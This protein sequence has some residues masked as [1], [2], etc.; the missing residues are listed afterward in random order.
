MK[1]LRVN[2]E[3]TSSLGISDAQWSARPMMIGVTSGN[4]I[5]VFDLLV[6]DSPTTTIENDC[7]VTKLAF[8]KSGSV[9]GTISTPFFLQRTI[10]ITHKLTEII[11]LMFHRNGT[12]AFSDEKGWIHVWK[13]PSKLTAQDPR[14]MEHFLD[15]TKV[16][17]EI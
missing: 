3:G 8:N 10:S 7:L 1:E 6:S 12:V 11:Y 14:E 16:R 4:T 17:T 15:V 13:L 9:V 5:K 2:E